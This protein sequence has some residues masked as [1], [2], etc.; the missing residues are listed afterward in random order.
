MKR[1]IILAF[2]LITALSL[3]A[4]TS[5]DVCTGD[6]LVLHLT[7]PISASVQW[8]Q[9]LDGVQFFDIPGGT[10]DSLMIP[11]TTVSRY[12]RAQITGPVC[13]P[14]FSDIE[15]VN[16]IPIP[17]ITIT[18]LDSAYCTTDGTVTLTGSPSGGTFTGAGITGNTLN[19]ATAGAGLQNVTYTY[20][21]SYGC[22]NSLHA[23]YVINAPPTT[24]NAGPDITATS[25]TVA[26]AGNALVV[27]TGLW[28][29]VSGT[30]GSFANATSPTT[31]FTGQPNSV[32]AIVWT[33]SNPPC[34][35]STDTVIVTMPTGPTL[36]SV[37][38]GSPSYTLYVHPTDNAG[39]TPWGCSGIVTNANSDN[40]GAANTALIVQ[41]CPPPTAAAI[42][43]N[44]V[45]FGYSDW[46]LPSYNELECLR[47]N[48][49]TIGGFVS[50]GYWSSTEHATFNANAMMRTFPSGMS[51]ISG[52]SNSHN[53]RCVR[54]D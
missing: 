49:A 5:H 15:H 31:N 19:I 28:T 53:I 11:G 37:S 27:G 46:Y 20:T 25:N 39:P 36:P 26:M 42:C 6:T 3:S 21:D 9:S 30:G 7:V 44:L 13:N 54:K 1:I 47:V 48:A 33:I 32:Y 52:K 2:S 45:A 4:Q 8:Q 18:G 14:Y 23:N 17:V 51:G 43:N 10:G 35:P 41:L 29:I 34:T 16:V 22:S 24:A 50:G 40:N 12:Y 38:C